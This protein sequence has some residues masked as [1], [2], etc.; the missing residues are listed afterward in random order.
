MLRSPAVVRGDEE[1]LEA[2]RAGDTEAGTTLFRRFFGPCRRFFVNKVPERDADDLLQKTFT[3]IVES[4]ERFRGDASFRCF[5]FS[6][7]RRVL[8]RYLRDYA[9]RDSKRAIDFNVSSIALLG[10]T[11][12]S[13]IAL[14]RDQQLVRE[15]LQRIPVHFQTIIELSYWEGLT[16]AE[17][18]VTLDI[19]PT[20]VRTRLFRARAALAKALEGS[21]LAADPSLER[22]VKALGES[23]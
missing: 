3:A 8:M 1:L 7:A 14:E 19:E 10:V 9:R 5:L 12:G 18:S 22:A 13:A 20:T 2:W 4:R 15:A 17:L 11:P 6:I 16:P 23:L 21:D